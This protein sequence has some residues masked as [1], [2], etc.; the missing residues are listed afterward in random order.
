MTHGS[1]KFTLLDGGMGRELERIGAPFRQP[2][3]SALALIEASETVTQAHKN[4]ITAGADIITTNAY[5]LIPFHI[6]QN[7]FEQDGF[8]LAQ[9]AAQLAR[10][11]ATKAKRAIRVAGCLPPLFGS[12][13]PDLFDP[14]QAET[15]LRPL[16]EAQAPYVD[17][18][19]GETLSCCAEAQIIAQILQSYHDKKPLWLSFNLSEK[20]N[21]DQPATLR[22]GEPLKQAYND[23]HHNG[24][25]A[26]L[27]NCNT[28]EDTIIALKEIAAYN[29]PAL[30]FG[31][32]ANSF[33]PVREA[34]ERMPAS[35]QR[36]MIC[37]R[38]NIKK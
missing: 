12:Y 1:H 14:T 25:A 7:R 30:P 31:A 4:F 9:K 29:G 5:A 24:A 21:Q 38:W 13:R 28:P 19:L 32:Y 23:A 2:E 34:I 10:D 8:V 33:A 26:F 15:I 16:I 11:A 27:L 18:W 22:S 37:H 20:L 6:G 36:A 3:W 35:T 17:L